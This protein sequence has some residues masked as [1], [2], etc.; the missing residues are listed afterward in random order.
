[1]LGDMGEAVSENHVWTLLLARLLEDNLPLSRVTTPAL[2]RFLAKVSPILSA[3]VPRSGKD[4][5]SIIGSKMPEACSSVQSAVSKV[6][7]VFDTWSSPIRASVLGIIGRYINE[8]YKLVLI[9]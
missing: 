2:R 6:H 9:F 7:L 1:M 4:L 5:K 8:Q 3:F